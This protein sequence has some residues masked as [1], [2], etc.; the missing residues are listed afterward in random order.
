MTPSRNSFNWNNSG[1]IL[2]LI[3][4]LIFLIS[5]PSNA[6]AQ[7]E[8]PLVNDENPNNNAIPESERIRKDVTPFYEIPFAL[9]RYDH[10]YLARPINVDGLG[11]HDPDFRYGYLY[12]DNQEIHTGL[13]F[14]GPLRHPVLSAG[15]GEV[16]FAG[17][18]LT[19]GP[20]PEEDPYGI[21]VMIRHTFG[22]DG[23]DLYT[24]Y[25]HLDS[26][27]VEVGDTVST[28]EQIGRIGLTG[29]TSG[30]HIHFEVRLGDSII[31]ELQ[32]PEFWLVP[33]IDTGV[34]S[35]KIMNT[36]GEFLAAKQIWLTSKDTGKKYKLISYAAAMT[37]R[38]IHYHEN[39]AL[40]DIPAGV[41]E[42]STYYDYR[43][44]Q[45]TIRIVP[46]AITTINFQGTKGFY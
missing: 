2:V 18:G 9:T 21:V 46:G 15:D 41:Y 33:E 7:G 39:L 6:I 14:P 35:G 22:F 38:D 24:I 25:A 20:K 1:R 5:I 32:N 42:I 37:D 43:L 30:P 34:L 28:G 16:V 36:N 29:A 31:F 27:Q 40:N 17:Y 44:Y 10:F 3:L 4:A 23:K 11:Y 13:D 12:E 8:P 19:H 45:R 26:T